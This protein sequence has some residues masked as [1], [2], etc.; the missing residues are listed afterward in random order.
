MAVHAGFWSVAVLAWADDRR[1]V[2]GAE[3]TPLE[4]E[5]SLHRLFSGLVEQVF[6]V[7][8]GLCEPRL[9]EYLAGLLAEFVHVDD[10]FRLRSVDH[11]AIRELSRIEAEAD[12]GPD[13]DEA[14][15][16]RLIHKYIGDFTLFWTG[17]YPETLR[18]RRASS[19]DQLHVYL[20]SGKRSYGI[21]SELTRTNQEPD[22]DTLLQLSEQFEHC[23]RGL[24]LV[25]AG[26]EEYGQN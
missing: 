23:V 1:M 11:E 10:I 4:P 9:T 7:E 24:R 3:M 16:R 14:T 8:I 6:F 21:A 13:V 5:H 19:V 15:R 25:R 20:A 18:A 2:P 12:L 26:W 17:V 22:A